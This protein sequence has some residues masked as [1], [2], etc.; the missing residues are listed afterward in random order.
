MVECGPNDT[1][2]PPSGISA[3]PDRIAHDWLIDVDLGLRASFDSMLPVLADIYLHQT[4]DVWIARE[5]SEF[6]FERHL[7]AVVV[8]C[9]T[10]RQA[11]FVLGEIETWMADRGLKLNENNATIFNCKD[12]RRVPITRTSSDSNDRRAYR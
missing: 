4:F 7:D 12:P 10:K 6:P 11:W 1:Y 5:F 9:K 3:V 2:M 8:H